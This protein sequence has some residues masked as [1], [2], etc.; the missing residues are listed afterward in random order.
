M[1]R[2]ERR[3]LSA[4]RSRF[5]TGSGAAAE[6]EQL[7]AHLAANPVL[8][9]VQKEV[10]APSGFEGSGRRFWPCERTGTEL[11]PD[12]SDHT[13]WEPARFGYDVIESI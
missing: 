11:Q 2:G 8:Q 1:Q 9:Q 4:H 6:V 7:T 5:W 10:L 3:F 12:R 13:C